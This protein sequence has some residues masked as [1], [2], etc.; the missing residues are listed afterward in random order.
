MDAARTAE[1][2]LR[3]IRAITDATLGHL[4]VEDL[5]DELLDRVREILAADT[6]AVLLLD[7]DSS[8]LV[9]RA[10]RGIEEEVRQGVR[11]PL[12]AGFAGRIASEKRPLI[13]DRVDDTTV[14]NPILWQKGIRAMLGVPLLS[15]GRVLGV[16]HVGTLGARQFTNEDAELLQLVA[17]RVAGAAQARLVQAERA[18][19]DALQRGLLPSAFP[20][21]PGLE[22]AGRHAAA[23]RSIGG[24]WYDV[25][26]VPSGEVWVV[27]GDVVG[28][29]LRA[30]AVMGRLRSTIRAYALDGGEPD[31]VLTRTDRSLQHFEPGEMATVVCAVFDP[32]FEDARLSTAGHPPP[33][34]VGPGQPASILELDPA[35]PLGTLPDLKRSS[36]TVAVPAGTVVFFDTAGL[37]ERRGE[38]LDLGLERL[39][40]AVTPE[41]PAAV[42]Q[43]TMA[44][45]VG[46]VGADDDI[47]IIAVRRT[48]EM[49]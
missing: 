24:D 12:G 45:L 11:I 9:A 23:R 34:L 42:C 37:I 36:T 43:R 48:A 3:D 38:S 15:T 22:F 32:S 5:L 44:L 28:H 8:E 21:V 16:L 40:A 1:D 26:A 35:P 17:D 20:V 19:T 4:D 29:G 39:R 30:A 10:A 2:R 27:S 31:D 18:A 49:G 6:A 33:I 47:A 46:D 14:A 41:H 25:F 7:E 13:L